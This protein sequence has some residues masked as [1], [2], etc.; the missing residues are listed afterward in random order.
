MSTFSDSHIAIAICEKMVGKMFA[1]MRFK[2]NM[3]SFQIRKADANDET[4]I[5][6][7]LAAAF[8][9]Y[10]HQYTPEAFADTVLDSETVHHRLREMSVFVAVSEGK[11]VGTIGCSSHGVEGHLRG[12]AVMPNWQGTMAASAL[13]QT[14]ETELVKNGCVRVTLDTTEPLIRAIRFYER[15]GYSPTGRISDFFGMRLY[16]Y[17]KELSDPSK[18][19][20]RNEV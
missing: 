14:A 11:I 3:A 12:M 6:D 9:K 7:C 1:C 19:H 5:L 17:S 18:P 2:I 13:L 16:E 15:H 4:A 20:Q 10:R 8:E